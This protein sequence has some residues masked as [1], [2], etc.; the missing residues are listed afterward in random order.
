MAGIFKA[1]SM[2]Y[3]LLHSPNI[4]LMMVDRHNLY[5]RKTEEEEEGREEETGGRER[6]R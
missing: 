1:S 5:K 6:G 2:V 4:F 3:G